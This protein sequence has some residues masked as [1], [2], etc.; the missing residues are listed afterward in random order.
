MAG[1]SLTPDEQ[2]KLNDLLKEGIRLAEQ[3]GDAAA[4]ASLEGFTGSIKDA[5]KELGKLQKEWKD[6]TSDVDG[7]RTGFQN[8]LFEIQML[9]YI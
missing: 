4:K 8:I 1:N 2:K 9:L 3:L 7:T 5:E 6:Y